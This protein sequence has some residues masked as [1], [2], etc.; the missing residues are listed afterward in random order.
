MN[1]IS[2]RTG[3]RTEFVDT[4]RVEEI[5][6]LFTQLYDSMYNATTF[7]K[8]KIS[9]DNEFVTKNKKILTEIGADRFGE[10]ILM[11]EYRDLS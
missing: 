4:G 11:K 3:S 2:V 10:L 6:R 1:S 8:S 9:D 5:N 7:P